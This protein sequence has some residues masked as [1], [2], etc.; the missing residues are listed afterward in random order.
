[1]VVVNANSRLGRL[2]LAW[3]ALSAGIGF[4]LWV[5]VEFWGRD[6]KFNV[7]P[8]I[9]STHPQPRVIPPP[10]SAPL[11]SIQEVT[12]SAA[13]LSFLGRMARFDNVRVTEVVQLTFHVASEGGDT[14]LVASS[15]LGPLNVRV[16]ER[17]NLQGLILNV[18]DATVIEQIWNL[19][20]EQ[21]AQAERQQ[22]YLR[23][24]TIEKNGK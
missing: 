16:G 22:I 24:S 5:A 18:P 8:G 4:L 10:N 3:L 21:A 12:E 14:L 11:M 23:A 6:L 1:M 20:P 17:V 7:A 19:N 15:E 2:F 9:G 13:K